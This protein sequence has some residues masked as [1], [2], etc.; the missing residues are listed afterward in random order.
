MMYSGFPYYPGNSFFKTW[1]YGASFNGAP[2][3]L[4]AN[5]VYDI[6][7]LGKKFNI[8]PLGW[9]TDHWEVSGI[10][11]WQSHGMYGAPGISM[12]GTSSSN[13]APNWTGS[14]EGARLVVIGNPTVAN[15]TFYNNINA[16]AFQ[17]PV[18]CSQTRQTMD[19]FG[20]AGSGSIFSVPIWMNNWD[21]SLIK[22]I[23]IKSEH[24]VLTFRAEFYNLP[25]HT[26][27]SSI[28]NT[29]QFDLSSYQNWIA[30]KGSLV[31]S[32]SQFGRYTGARNPRQV[33]MTLR[34][35]F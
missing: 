10:T 11:S 35:Q 23:P 22:N 26:Q 28:N 29:L 31:Q 19:C 32:N 33:A 5:Y 24:R 13:P 9:V 17:L 34:F 21:M 2:H 4:T 18:A 27:F 7:G 6:P 16:S 12:T 20:N 1:Y 8:R 30:G 14:A 25:N 3:V 15:P